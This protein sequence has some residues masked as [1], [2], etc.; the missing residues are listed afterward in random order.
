MKI[1]WDNLEKMKFTKNGNWK[2][3][4]SVYY[5]KECINCQE[6]YLGTI[7]SKFCSLSCSNSGKF[8]NFYGKDFSGSFNP[9]YNKH[10]TKEIKII[11]SEKN[12]ISLL[13]NKYAFKCGDLT[14]YDTHAHKISWCEEVRRAPDNENILEVKCKYCGKWFKPTNSQITGKYGSLLGHGGSRNLYCSNKCKELCPIY[15]KQKFQENHPN[16]PKTD[17]GVFPELRKMVLERDNYTCQKCGLNSNE[18]CVELHCHHINPVKLDPLESADIDNCTT[19]CIDC[20]HEA[21]Q[22]D[23]CSTGYLA[24]C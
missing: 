23:G 2:K 22:K 5:E 11:I 9:F 21:H 6:S 18:Q 4:T 14:W 19:L 13:N 3:N 1:C 16:K 8:W 12:K 15:Y 17:T 10:H 20:H 24:N 7:N